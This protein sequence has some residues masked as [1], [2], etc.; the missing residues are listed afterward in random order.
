MPPKPYNKAILDKTKTS[1]QRL[2]ESSESDVF[3]SFSFYFRLL[4]GIFVLAVFGLFCDGLIIST[5]RLFFRIYLATFSLKKIKYEFL[6]IF[7]KKKLNYYLFVKQKY[8][9]FFYAFAFSN[10]YISHLK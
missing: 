4:K 9:N 10:K 1:N 3:S 6:L 2:L 7:V 8:D 5:L